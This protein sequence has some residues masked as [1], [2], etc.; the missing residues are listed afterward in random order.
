MTVKLLYYHRFIILVKM[1]RLKVGKYLIKNIRF[2]TFRFVPPLRSS[3]ST[4]PI[5]IYQL[6]KF[7]V[8]HVHVITYFLLRFVVL[9]KSKESILFYRFSMLLISIFVFT[10]SRKRR[11]LE[12][13]F[14]ATYNLAIKERENNKNFT[15]IDSSHEPV[16]NK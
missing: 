11:P 3:N 5:F 6:I 1:T 13:L 12:H 14:I 7:F 16:Q 4:L 15:K 10:F 2:I 9:A 8:K